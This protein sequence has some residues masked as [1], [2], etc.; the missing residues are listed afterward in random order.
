LKRHLQSLACAKYKVLK[1]HPPGRDINPTDTFSFNGDF[2][3][4]L[5]KIKIATVSSKIESKVERKETSE[6][7]DEERKYLME[8]WFYLIP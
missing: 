8:V 1:K 5:N 3:C 4:S 7:I 2:S 6:R